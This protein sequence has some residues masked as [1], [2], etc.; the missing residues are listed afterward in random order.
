MFIYFP[1]VRLRSVSR[2]LHIKLTWNWTEVT[3]SITGHLVNNF[4]RSGRYGS[5]GHRS[6]V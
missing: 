3:G 1:Y 2:I 5:S 6:N 4:S